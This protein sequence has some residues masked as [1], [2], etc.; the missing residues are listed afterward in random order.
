MNENKT[1]FII[2]ALTYNIYQSE[3]LAEEVSVCPEVVVL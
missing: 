1:Y 3:K 2:E